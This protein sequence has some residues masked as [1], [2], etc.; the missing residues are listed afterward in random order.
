MCYKILKHVICLE[1][2]INMSV[3]LESIFFYYC[4]QVLFLFFP[5]SP[6]LHHWTLRSLQSC[7]IFGIKAIPFIFF[8]FIFCLLKKTLKEQS[9]SGKREEQTN[10]NQT[11]N[12]KRISSPNRLDSRATLSS[13]SY[14]TSPGQIWA[15]NACSVLWWP[16]QSYPRLE[17]ILPKFSAVY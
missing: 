5:K 13:A 9:I 11:K 10:T 3:K 15:H 12:K 4:Y 14:L 16:C 17:P 1:W 8:I 2:A 6:N 7:I